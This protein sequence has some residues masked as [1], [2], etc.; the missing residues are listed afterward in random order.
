MRGPLWGAGRE[1]QNTA[2]PGPH[3]QGTGPEAEQGGFTPSGLLFQ[4][5]HSLLDFISC[6]CPVLCECSEDRDSQ[7]AWLS[8]MLQQKTV[9]FKCSRMA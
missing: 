9:A 7:L 8:L 5:T 3:L 6:Q 2:G 1:R 4:R